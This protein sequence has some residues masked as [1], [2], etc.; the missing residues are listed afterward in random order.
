MRL[1]VFLFCIA[2][3]VFAP[4]ALGSTV[5]FTVEGALTWQ[6][7]GVSVAA[8]DRLQIT[9]TGSIL[10]LPPSTTATAGGGSLFFDPN[11]FVPGADNLSL[12]GKIGA[13]PARFTGNLLPEGITGRG[14]GYVG[15]SYDKIIPVSGELYLAFNDSFFAD[16]TG[17][18]TSVITVT[19]AA[20][21]LPPIA[22]SGFGLISLLC[23]HRRFSR[24][25]LQM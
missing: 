2:A 24:G 4:T 14:A 15:N 12:V 11:S 9:T 23:L 20:V 5:T 13:D 1:K 10:F 19:P 3:G 18:F 6:D 7:T 8:G 21:P 25:S 22:W 17:S 16:N